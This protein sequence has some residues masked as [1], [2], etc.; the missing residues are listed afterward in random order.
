MKYFILRCV[1]IILEVLFYAAI[2]SIIVFF[3]SCSSV[4]KTA[5][6]NTAGYQQTEKEIQDILKHGDNLSP[7][8]KIV[9]QHAAADLKDAQAVNKK[10]VQLQEKLITASEKAGAG[11]LIY[12]I[13]YTV[14]G[15]MAL[16]LFTKIKGIFGF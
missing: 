10:A 2:V 3:V 15:G 4:Q 9:L 12:W 6:K 16:F 14:I 1:G 13:L 8:Q 7:A 11:K 5:Y